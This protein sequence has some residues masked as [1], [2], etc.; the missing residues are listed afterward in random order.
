M[1]RFLLLISLFFA[2]LAGKAQALELPAGEPGK[3][4]MSIS[5]GK[6]GGVTGICILRDSDAEVLGSVVNEF[7]IKAF[8]FVYNKKKDKTK[9]RNV[10]KMM[11]KWYIR[12]IV[13]SDLSVVIRE[14]NTEKQLR[15]RRLTCGGDS[16]ILENMKY[17]ITYKFHRI[18][19]TEQ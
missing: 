8:D 14:N 12:K 10:I 17:N 19:D 3:Y 11:N 15:K 2:V 5:I 13:G 18:D 1:K 6:R 4:A 9:L 16:I 7:G